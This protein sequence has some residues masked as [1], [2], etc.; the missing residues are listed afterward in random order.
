M[1]K[2]AVSWVVYV[3]GAESRHA[4]LSSV[5]RQSEWDEMERLRPGQHTLV[6]S[7]IASEGEAEILARSGLV[8]AE[9]ARAEERKR[10]RRN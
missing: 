6:R 9:V 10:L 7:G 4:G 1:R 5:C 2:T 3:T 8:A